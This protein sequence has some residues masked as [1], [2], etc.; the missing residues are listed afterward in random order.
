MCIS[1]DILSG[2]LFPAVGRV[3]SYTAGC[4]LQI[5]EPDLFFQLCGHLGMVCHTRS[6]TKAALEAPTN[7]HKAWLD[8]SEIL[9]YTDVFS[10]LHDYS[11]G[12]G[13]P[14]VSNLSVQVT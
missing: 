10:R 13:F 12:F 7:C 4:S 9:L 3:V 14:A 1:S 6:G 5:S 11:E 8:T 2:A